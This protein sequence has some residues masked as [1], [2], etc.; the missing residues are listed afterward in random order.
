MSEVEELDIY[1]CVFYETCI[2]GDFSNGVFYDGYI[3]TFKPI[4]KRI[5]N[6]FNEK[7]IIRLHAH[8]SSVYWSTPHFLDEKK[9]FD[10]NGENFERNPPFYIKHDRGYKYYYFLS[11]EPVERDPVLLLRDTYRGNKE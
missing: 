1:L 5:I 11:S 8:D 4:A 3:K 9:L 2:D 7:G 10:F 6:G